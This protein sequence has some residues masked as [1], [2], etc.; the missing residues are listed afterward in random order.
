MMRISI[1]IPVYDDTEALTRALQALQTLDTFATGPAEVIVV[2]T[3]EDAASLAPLRAARP[4]VVWLEAARGRARQ[5]NAGAAR[6]TG[7]WLIFLHADTRLPAE[8]RAAVE[9]A[10]RD[11]AISIGC[12]R[13]ALDSPSPVA[14][15]L[16]AGVR[17]RVWL[18]GLPYGD[19]ALF[20][21]R[22][23]FAA[24]GGYADVPIMEDVDLVRRFRRRGRV[25][26]APFPA[27]T[28]ARK[29]ERDGW[30]ARTGRHVVLILMYFAGVAPERLALYI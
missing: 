10:D 14:R 25:F 26:P 8:W 1:V 5:M 11:P 12:F 28:S 13:F 27:V 24:A 6:A 18:F 30:F 15:G 17:L 22:E 19:Q 4:D 2:S 20:V 3:S 9:A 21:R 23:D 7:R 29:W 16:E